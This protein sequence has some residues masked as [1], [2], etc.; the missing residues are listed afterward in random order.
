MKWTE[1]EFSKLKEKDPKIFEKLYSI[2]KDKIYNYLSYKTKGNLT[3]TDDLFSDTFQTAFNSVN[4]LKNSNN[5]LGWLL[6]IANRRL[7]DLL[8]K[9]YNE[10][11]KLDIIGEKIIEINRDETDEEDDI[12]L[13]L[14]AALDNLKPE[15][16]KILKMKYFDNMKLKEIAD[17]LNKNLKA[18]ESLIHR[19]KKVLKNEM[20]R[21]SNY[22]I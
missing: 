12:V 8:R 16:A 14:N 3:M 20:D 5:I 10:K 15:Y 17:E 6:I 11:K 18:V 19:A 22:F 9:Q 1:E 13:L 21:L 2:Y 7:N 4:K